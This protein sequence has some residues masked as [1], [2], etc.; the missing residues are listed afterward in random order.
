MKPHSVVLLLLVGTIALVGAAR[1]TA[2][3][4]GYQ[5]TA[6]AS[7]PAQDATSYSQPAQTVSAEAMCHYTMERR[8][9][10]TV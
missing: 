6:A 5:P 10:V 9:F 4:S 3:V 8:P 7:Q 1:T 2:P